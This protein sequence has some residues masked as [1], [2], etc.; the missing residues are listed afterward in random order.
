MAPIWPISV[1]ALPTRARSSRRATTLPAMLAMAAR[2]QTRPTS[3]P[4]TQPALGLSSY[5]SAL[6]PRSPRDLPTSRTSLASSRPV[7]ASETVGLE[8]PLT[9][10][11]CA[12][13]S[14]PRRWMSSSTERSL[15]A[16]SRLGV[17]A[18]NLLSSRPPARPRCGL[19][20]LMTSI[21]RK[22]SLRKTN[23]PRESRQE[24]ISSPP[25]GEA[26]SGAL[27]KSLPPEE[28]GQ[29]P[30]VGFEQRVEER[31]GHVVP[32]DERIG[33]QRFQGGLTVSVDGRV[34]REAFVGLDLLDKA[35]QLGRK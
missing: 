32:A 17:P 27:G 14:G 31:G 26:G 5:R 7:S 21:V 10:A 29:V 4:A 30:A 25:C 23:C 8:R 6:G 33:E 11:T 16:R 34:D 1:L 13:D 24:E 2:T 22:N 9:R 18:V 15:I 35:K 3:M 28:P 12:R 19:A 20:G